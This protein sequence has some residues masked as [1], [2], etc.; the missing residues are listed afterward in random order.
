MNINEIVSLAEDSTDQ[1]YNLVLSALGDEPRYL[2]S[3]VAAVFKQHYIRFNNPDS[4]RRS[5][6]RDAV[7]DMI[8]K[9]SDQETNAA[10]LKLK[11]QST[12]SQQPAPRQ[13][14]ASQ[15]DSVDDSNYSSTN[16]LDYT[17][18]D[19]SKYD[20]AHMVTTLRNR[21]MKIR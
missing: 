16:K 12:P 18:K 2:T 3:R 6:S 14:A 9:V 4:A 15:A 8:S 13:A 5:I 17:Q 1:L 20:I 21:G 19:Y 11:R 7:R 10:L